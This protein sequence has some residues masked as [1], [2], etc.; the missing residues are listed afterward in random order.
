M[1]VMLD[2][3][4]WST[5][6]NA[7]IAQISAIPFVYAKRGRIFQEHTFN[8]YVLLQDGLGVVDQGTVNWWMEQDSV[9]RAK[10][11]AGLQHEGVTCAE[12]LIRFEHW[13]LLVP[14][15]ESWENCEGFWSNGAA[16]DEP[17]LTNAFN[18]HG[19]P[20]P[21][22]YKVSRCYRTMRATFGE[23]EVDTTGMI[24]HYGPDDCLMQIMGLLKMLDQ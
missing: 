23:Q 6:P 24:P 22:S 10:L 11:I 7:A 2:L 13:P 8:A 5:R 18:Q 21:W 9:A 12:A 14:G 16:F 20:A 4:T 1:H 19:K 15:F 3:E 17:I